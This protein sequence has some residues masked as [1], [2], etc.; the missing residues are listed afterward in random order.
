MYPIK[1]LIH[2]LI[3]QVYLA[4]MS[5]DTWLNTRKKLEACLAD[6]S[7]WKSLNMLMLNQE[8][9]DLSTFRPKYQLD[10]K[11]ENPTSSRWG[12]FVRS[13][14]WK[15]WEYTLTIDWQVNAVY[16]NIGHITQ[17]TTRDACNIL[18]HALITS[19]LDYGNPLLYGGLLR[20]LMTLSQRVQN[21]AARP[22]PYNT[23]L[24]FR[25]YKG[26]IW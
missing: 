4:I 8:N 16:L 17:Y 10:I 3:H 26:H 24:F 19:Q 21:S 5:K 14:L 7:T 25:S 2:Y 20:T 18:A 13:S 23:S 9:T 15:T 6:I 11:G 12:K 1:F 22:V